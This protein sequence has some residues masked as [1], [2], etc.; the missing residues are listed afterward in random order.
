[1]PVLHLVAILLLAVSSNLDN[2][3]VGVS[4]GIRKINIPI[5]SNL[6]IAV[7]TS[8]GTFLSILLGGAIY[9]FLSE[10]MAGLLGGGIIILAGIWVIFQEKVMHQGCEP[11]EEKQ[12]IAETGPSRFGFRQ[13]VMILNNPIIADRDFSGHIDLREATALAFGLTLNNIPNGVGAGMLGFSLSITTSAVFLFSI[14]T[15]WIGIYFGELGIHWM[16]K[17]TGLISGLILIFLGIYEIFF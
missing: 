2:V 17:S 9:N 11:H 8:T 12:I 10:A 6:L 1:M 3:G 5:T 4:Y 13:L 14:I 15:I 16:G 7:V